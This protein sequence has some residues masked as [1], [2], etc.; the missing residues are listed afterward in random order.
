[1]PRHPAVATAER[2]QVEGNYSSAAFR[3]RTIGIG[4]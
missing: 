3:I 1:M 4:P 2:D